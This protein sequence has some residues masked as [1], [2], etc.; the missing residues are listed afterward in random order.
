MSMH[1][2][3]QN[4]SVVGLCFFVTATLDPRMPLFA[5]AANAQVIVDSLDFF[6]HRQEIEL[7]GFVVMPDHVHFVLKVCGPAQLPDLMRRLKSFVAKSLNRGP[8][9]LK[10]YWSE[11]I[12]DDHHLQQKLRYLHENPV[13]AGLVKEA[14][15]FAWS[16]AADYYLQ[17]QSSRIDAY[18]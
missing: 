3:P 18:R 9:W 5:V 15:E 2:V 1:S 10:G 12:A 14:T 4:R 8:I 6:R 16:S 13:R 11:V 7:Y 17:S